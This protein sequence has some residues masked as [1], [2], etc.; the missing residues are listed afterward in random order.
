MKSKLSHHLKTRLKKEYLFGRTILQNIF[1]CFF[2]LIIF[3]YHPKP[4]T[5]R[6]DFSQGQGNL[7]R[8][9]CTAIGMRQQCW[10]WCWGR[11]GRWGHSVLEHLRAEK[12]TVC[13]GIVQRPYDQR[14]KG[15]QSKGDQRNDEN[16]KERQLEENGQRHEVEQTEN[17]DAADE[18]G[19]V[20]PEE[21]GRNEV[22]VKVHQ[23]DQ[24]FAMLPHEDGNPNGANGRGEALAAWRPC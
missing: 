14:K 11:W 7:F 19:T 8:R 9:Y 24:Q 2:K 5:F 18:H 20:E 22:P 23:V 1:Y 15:E 6:L 3:A 4:A 21:Q 16:A 12:L 17:V 13:Q 10:S